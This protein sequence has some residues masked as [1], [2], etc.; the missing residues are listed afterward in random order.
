MGCHLAKDHGDKQM[1]VEGE[2]SRREALSDY[3]L[4]FAIASWEDQV[5]SASGFASAKEAAIELKHLVAEAN[6]RGWNIENK[7]P[8]KRG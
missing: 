7:Y 3:E 4:Q 1:T 8:I 6:R 5:R 2:I